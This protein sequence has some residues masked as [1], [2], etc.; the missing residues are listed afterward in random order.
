MFIGQKLV[1]RS[2]CYIY[3]CMQINRDVFYVV[4]QT[5]GFR[6]LFLRRPGFRF[7]CCAAGRICRTRH[8]DARFAL[9]LLFRPRDPAPPGE[10]SRRRRL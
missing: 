2:G 5:P 9:Y 10:L 7:R 8:G 3:I 6:P 4:S 1:V